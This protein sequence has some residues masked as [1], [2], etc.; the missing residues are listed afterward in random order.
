M[1]GRTNVISPIYAWNT[2]SPFAGSMANKRLRSSFQNA[3]MLRYSLEL[4]PN[5]LASCSVCSTY[6]AKLA[7]S[8]WAAGEELL[9]ARSRGA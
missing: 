1:D 8:G 6:Y 4:T 3:K 2:S 5:R 9:L 7:D